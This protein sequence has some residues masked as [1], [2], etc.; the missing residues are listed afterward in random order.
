MTHPEDLLA[1]YV[2]GALSTRERAA[3]DAHL[4][5]CE[6]CRE[7]IALAS[8]VVTMLSA[9]PEE[10]VPLGVTAPVLETARGERVGARARVSRAERRYAR[11][12][13]VAGAAAALLVLVLVVPNL[14]HGGNAEQRGSRAKFTEVGD[15]TGG[16]GAPEAA[17]LAGPGVLE[18]QSGTDYDTEGLTTLARDVALS[19][20]DTQA[21]MAPVDVSDKATATALRCLQ[22]G[23]K[24]AA[25]RVPFR[26]IQAKFQGTPAFIGVFLVSP[27][28]GLPPDSVEIWVVTQS[29]CRVVSFTSQQI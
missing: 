26:L 18:D 29:A 21:S 19:Q 5:S 11:W 22:K 20:R 3:V 15:A 27:G 13:W 16:G 4:S 24:L 9:L 14:F 23:S 25:D 6:T 28:A 2:D 1:G 17:T 12:Q 8:Q 7:E 10:D